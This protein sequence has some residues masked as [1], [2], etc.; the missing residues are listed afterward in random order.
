MY[1]DPDLTVDENL[2]SADKLQYESFASWH[3]ARIRRRKASETSRN[4][5]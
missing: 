4:Q 3:A 2:A 5:S 1:I